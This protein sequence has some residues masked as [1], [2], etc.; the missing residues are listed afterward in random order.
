[1]KHFL[2]LIVAVVVLVPLC[3]FGPPNIVTKQV[4]QY[5]NN[6]N[7]PITYLI[8]LDPGNGNYQQASIGQIATP[9]ANTVSNSLVNAFVLALNGM[10]TNETF[11]NVTSFKGTS[12]GVF[13][14]TDPSG[15]VLGGFLGGVFFGNGSG[16]TN[17]PAGGFSPYASN[18]ISGGTAPINTINYTPATNNDILVTNYAALVVGVGATNYAALVVGVGAT[19]YAALVVGV[20]ATNNSL[21]V[22]NG[23]VAH[24]VQVQG[25]ANQINSSVATAQQLASNPSTTLSLP[26]PLIAPG[27]VSVVGLTNAVGVPS[28]IASYDAKTNLIG[29]ANGGANTFLQGTTPPTYTTVA[30]SALANSTITFTDGAGIGGSGSPTSLGGTYTTSTKSATPQFAGISLTGLSSSPVL[31]LNTN[32]MASATNTLDF[33]KTDYTFV[34]PTAVS[35]T[36]FANLPT[37]NSANIVLTLVNTAGTNWNLTLPT[38]VLTAT[39]VRGTVTVT[40]GQDRIIWIR[41][42]P[43]SNHTNECDQPNF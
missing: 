1:M 17:L 38:S 10:G 22:S 20:G 26:S 34:S 27:I 15:N 39:G 24:T 33:T 32:A 23:V 6:P 13:V 28:A 42:N 41:Y 14:C 30:N 4:N 40:N 37:T 9:F 11:W 43:G 31:Q 2:K 35:V 7:P 18:I 25:T 5:P 3:V 16:L 21:L 12:N 29:I 36:G 8:L 19:N